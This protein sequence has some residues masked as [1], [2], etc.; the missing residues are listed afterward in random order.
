MK[1]IAIV[2]A[3]AIGGSIGAYLLRK[4]YDITLIDQWAAHIEKMNSDGLKLTDL[5]ETFSVPVKGFHI[6]EVSNIRQPFDIVYL[7]VKSYDTRWSTYLLEPLLK[8]TGFVLPAQNG[9]NDE[10]VARIV[11]FQ[12]TV[13][14][15]PSI[16]AGVYEPGHIIR[17]DPMVT[18]CFTVGELSGIITPRVREAVEA[19]Q[20]LG[21]SKTTSNIWGAR[22]AK[23][24]GNCM[25]NALSGIIGPSLSTLTR[26][27]IDLAEIIRVAIGCEVV[28]V[29]QALGISVEP[30]G[31][32]SAHK[33]A[34]SRTGRD[35]QNLKDIMTKS[36]E[37]RKLTEEQIKRLGIPGRP[38]LLQDVIKGRRTEIDELNGYITKKGL[39]LGIPTPINQA[40]VKTMIAVENGDLEPDPSNMNLIK[41]FI[42]K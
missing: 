10:S 38:S 36:R 24:V 17:T 35:I 12:R 30:V 19:L 7:S 16:S 8:P 9:L 22:W 26:E 41:P 14:C 11:G 15:V 4:G 29:A 32:V 39:E 13:G 6:S 21:P 40:V 18:H 27:Q 31:R 25:V 34:E 37:N 2:G 1:R 3:G 20:V 33:F 28:L 42:P 23:L 5:K